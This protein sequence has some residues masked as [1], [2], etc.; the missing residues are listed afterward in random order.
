MPD[1]EIDFQEKENLKQLG[2]I[3][4]FIDLSMSVLR[5]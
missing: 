1:R 4:P 2:A 5:K 3:I